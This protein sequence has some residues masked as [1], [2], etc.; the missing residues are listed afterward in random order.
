MRFAARP[1]GAHKAAF[2]PRREKIPSMHLI[3]VVFPVPGPP[4]ITVT[5]LSSAL[6]TAFF[7]MAAN[8]MPESA[9]LRSI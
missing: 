6:V 3:I 7:C 8:L 2:I 4:V 9:S 5:G 1:V